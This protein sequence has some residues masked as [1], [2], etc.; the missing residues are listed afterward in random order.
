[1]TRSSVTTEITMSIKVRVLL[2]PGLLCLLSLS[3]IRS[4]VIRNIG[5]GACPPKPDTVPDLDVTRV[6][7]H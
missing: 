6:R 5:P 4:K 3:G 2:T 1:M 7:D